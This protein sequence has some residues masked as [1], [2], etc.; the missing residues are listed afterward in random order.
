VQGESSG[1]YRNRAELLKKS[2]RPFHYTAKIAVDDFIVRPCT[3]SETS[4]S[5]ARLMLETDA[6]G[7]V[8]LIAD[9]QRRHAAPFRLIWR[10]GLTVGVEFATG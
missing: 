1:N 3:N 2:R 9:A 7:S 8:H 4:H 6:A 10:T 5:G